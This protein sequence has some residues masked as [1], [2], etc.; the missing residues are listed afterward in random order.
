M[1][2]IQITDLHLTTPGGTV[3]DSD[4][5]ARLDACI[6]DI[7]AHHADADLCVGTGDLANTGEREA[8]AA[9][10]ERLHSLPMPFRLLVGNHDDRTAFRSV[11]ADHP[12]DQDGFVQSVLDIPEGRLRFLDTREPGL[13]SGEYCAKR[14]A[15]LTARLDEAGGRACYIF[16]HH[17]PFPVGYRLADDLKL[18]P[19]EAFAAILRGHDVRH[20]FFGHIH[21]PIAGSWHGIAFTTLRGL[22]H[23]VW[24]DFTVRNA[25]P[26]SMEPP[27]YAIVLIDETSVVVHTHDFLD[28]SRKWLYRYD[29]PEGQR[30]VRL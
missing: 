24:L 9:L 18:I 2:I 11:F 13:A 3:Y 20:I 19:S 4:P 12:V 5:L 7:K 6:A 1:K 22:N 27:A 15:W 10:R 17:H 8:Y 14:Q 23:Q 30:I 28:D 16:M 29:L 21:R 25:V 26:F